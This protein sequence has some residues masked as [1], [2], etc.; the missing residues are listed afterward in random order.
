[1][2][3]LAACM[4]LSVAAVLRWNPGPVRAERSLEF[5]VVFVTYALV[6][7]CAWALALEE[8]AVRAEAD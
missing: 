1:V 6:P 5:V 2:A 4:V 3:W 8:R 7:V